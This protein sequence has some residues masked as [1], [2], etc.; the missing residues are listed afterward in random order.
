MSI[1]PYPGHFRL[2]FPGLSKSGLQEIQLLWKR[3]LLL[4]RGDQLHDDSI[5]LVLSGLLLARNQHDHLFAFAWGGNCLFNLPHFLSGQQQGFY[6]E[7]ARKTTVIAISKTD[8]DSLRLRIP[9]VNHVWEKALATEIME[10]TLREQE[11]LLRNPSERFESLIKRHP[12]WP[13]KLPRKYLASY[14]GLQPET[15]SRLKKY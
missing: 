15:L 14:L 13:Q 10:Q 3:T 9:E 5:Y 2:I 7:A 11:L 6:L 12:D 1:L 4:K 8:F